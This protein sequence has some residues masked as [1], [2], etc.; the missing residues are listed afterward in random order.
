M[1]R[2]RYASSPPPGKEHQPAVSL[3]S[4]PTVADFSPDGTQLVIAA[5][6][7]AVIANAESGEIEET[8]QHED[9]LVTAV[10]FRRTGELVT[11]GDDGAISTWHFG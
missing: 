3:S 7:R 6:G 5:G 4:F 1:A 8:L 10:E 2:A 11:A 9:G